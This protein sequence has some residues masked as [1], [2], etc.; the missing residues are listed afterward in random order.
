MSSSQKQIS[1]MSYEPGG[2]RKIRCPQQGHGYSADIQLKVPPGRPGAA[3]AF[4]EKN[5][6]H[7]PVRPLAF[8]VVP[9]QK[10]VAQTRLAPVCL[11]FDHNAGSLGVEAG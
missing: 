10:A 4:V 5:V 1:Q 8:G 2:W 11:W 9:G 7:A 3:V 6:E